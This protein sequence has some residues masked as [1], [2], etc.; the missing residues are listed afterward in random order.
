[1]VAGRCGLTN[2]E[3]RPDGDL[4]P[5]FRASINGLATL[6]QAMSSTK[7]SPPSA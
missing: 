6:A 1:M 2:A 7:I 4:S 3:R 5:H